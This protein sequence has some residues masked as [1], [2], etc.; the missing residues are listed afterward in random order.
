MPI[1]FEREVSLSI[2]FDYILYDF[3]YF[4]MRRELFQFFYIC[5]LNF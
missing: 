3:K 2:G 5:S 4:G 1:Y